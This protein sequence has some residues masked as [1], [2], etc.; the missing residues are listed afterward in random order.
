MSPDVSDPA[1][2]AVTYLDL[3]SAYKEQVDALVD[4]GVDIVLFETTFDTLNVKAG[5]EAAEAV[6][7]EKGKDL[8]IMLSLT[9]SAQG[10]RTFSGQTLLAFLASVQHTNI[11]SVGLNCSFGAAD[12]KPFLAEL[13]KHAPY[14]IS[15]YPNAGLPNSF[16]SYD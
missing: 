12:M 6:L 11:V 8:P 9:L 16:G 4:G 1:Y 2:R 3:Y 13:A 5:L 14:Y 10:G 7:K 15:A